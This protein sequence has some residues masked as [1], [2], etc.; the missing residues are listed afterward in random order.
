MSTRL[1]RPAIWRPLG[2][3]AALLAF[4]GYLGFN[5]VSGQF[6][7]ESQKQMHVEIGELKAKSAALQAQIDAYRHR[8]GLFDPAKLDPDILTERAR[9]L[10]SMV[11]PDD[12]FVM[13]DPDSGKPLSSSSGE[14]S[15]N[16]LTSIIEG[17]SAL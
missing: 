5:V 7:V 13:V 2:L 10:L 11:Q 14:L 4:Q 3:T 9:A 1:K 17:T 8:I 12:I 15:A 16:Q 6:G